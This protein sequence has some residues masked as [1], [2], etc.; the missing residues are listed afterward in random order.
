LD[1]ASAERLGLILSFTLPVRSSTQI[2]RI[3]AIA[4]ALALTSASPRVGALVWPDVPER[5][6]HKLTS[7]DP[8]ARRAGARE[9]ASLGA[10]RATPLL[11]RALEDA[12]T[13]VRIAAADAAIRLRIGAATAAVLPWINGPIP[14]L[15]SKACEVASA[16]PDPQAVPA[17]SRALGDAELTVRAAAAA[18]LGA[19][20][21]VPDAVPPLVGRLDDA[22]PAVR[23]VIAQSLARLR[24]VRAVVPLVGKVHDSVPDV[25]GAI[26]RALGDL[27]DP[28]ATQALL[29]QLRDNVVDVRL[30]ALSALGKLRAGEAV[31][32]IAPL[33]V[34]RNPALRQA[35]LAALGRIGTP[36]AVRALVATLGQ[37][38][39]A[40]GG[41]ERTPARE[42]LVSAGPSA[43]AEVEAALERPASG[44]AATSAAWVL[45]E[46]HARDRA[47]AI[48]ASMRRGALPTAAA[49]H[50]LAGAGT[51][52]SL[53][54]VLEFTGDA[55]PLVRAQAL[56]AAAA[57][58]DPAAPDG[59]AVEPLTA[60]LN[61]PRSTPDERASIARLLG[62]TGAARAAPVLA[63]LAQ[64]RGATVRLAAIDAIGTLGP[65]A[66]ARKEDLEP[67]ID[68]L[69]DADPG[70]RLHAAVALA[71]AG[72]A[73]AREMILAKLDAVEVDRGAVLA[74]LGG[75]LTRA[76]S[77]DA[78]ARLRHDL[79]L[80]AGPERDAIAGAIGRARTPS[81]L[82][83]LDALA[84]SPDPDDA[85]T[86]ATLLAAQSG[87]ARAV[88]RAR[89]LLAHN[90]AGVRAQAAW[91]L[92][93]IGDRDDLRGLATLLHAGTDEAIDAAG[94]LGRIAGRL[95]EPNAAAPLCASLTDPRAHVRAAALAGLS[96]ARLRCGNGAAE[97]RLL[98]GDPND[99]VRA[100]AALAIGRLADHADRED[101]PALSRCAAEDRA[102]SVAARCR[103]PSPP[104]TR[105]RA[106]LVFIVPDLSSVPQPGEP[107]VLLLAD[108]TLHAGTADR[109]GAV[110]DPVAPEGDLMLL[111]SNDR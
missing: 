97:R 30:E 103:A 73:R 2:G 79:E 3:G 11:L 82:A 4:L 59:R 106:A 75:I 13:D 94:A 9:L 38:D 102:G 107:Y 96:V 19:Y 92:G 22:S 50:A 80:A 52:D 21:G 67:L 26:A 20:G 86:A 5:V 70:V 42:A 109:R 83:A 25:R 66:A 110:F 78:L 8:I 18:A 27:G 43:I 85:R 23:A 81:A 90:D 61:S 41:I 74:A 56:E 57:L 65:A 12:D 48:I 16:L 51:S 31:D 58:L 44:A 15:R 32:A 69:G 46:L 24:D 93:T 34:D 87:D 105:T 14:A 55:N 40:G 98:E 72:D 29:L 99:A 101:G 84:A 95:R 60:A 39:D 104:P 36:L 76:P 77:D 45:G 10:A 54:V 71:D 108:G 68:A 35:A 33:A 49:L 111:R 17:L 28:R 7:T 6:E 37:G 1:R 64:T 100:A 63:G 88:G 53:P 91:T 62:R 89:A 47:P